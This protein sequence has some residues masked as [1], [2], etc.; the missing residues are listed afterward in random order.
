M[1]IINLSGKAPIYEQIRGQ[2]LRFIELGVLAPGEKLPSVRQLAQDN[3]INPNT[4][5]RAYGELEQ[6]GYIV[7]VPKKGAYVAGERIAP[8]VEEELRRVIK[9]CRAAGLTQDR[10]FEIAEEEYGEGNENA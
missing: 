8:P 2:I 3:A 9:A 6:A 1:F 4:V 5:A 10:V 7:T